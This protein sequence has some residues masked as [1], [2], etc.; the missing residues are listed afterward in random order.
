MEYCKDCGCEL[1]EGEGKVFT[2][3]EI[4]WDKSE[5][6]ADSESCQVDTLVGL[7]TIKQLED[8]TKW[9][10]DE[11]ADAGRGKYYYWDDKGKTKYDIKTICKHY[12][13]LKAN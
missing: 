13:A 7:P 11:I 5:I 8:F 6:N 2:V 12:L 1:G 4:C 10:E 9:W 3:C